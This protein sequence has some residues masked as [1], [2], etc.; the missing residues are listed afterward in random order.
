MDR[1]VRPAQRGALRHQLARHRR[2]TEPADM[3]APDTNGT[4]RKRSKAAKPRPPAIEQPAA[5]FDVAGFVE[6]P[7]PP[8]DADMSAPGANGTGR[9][10]SKAAKPRPPA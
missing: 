7:L 6:E 5:P 8:I 9:K 1:R 4:G 10:R 2:Q 3:S